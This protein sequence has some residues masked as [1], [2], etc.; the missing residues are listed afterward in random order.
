MDGIET[1]NVELKNQL[2][3]TRQELEATRIQINTFIDNAPDAIITISSEDYRITSFNPGAENMFG[4]STDEV[5]GKNV[6]M[7]MPEP[8]RSRHDGYVEHYLNTGEKRIIGRIRAEKAIRK[9]GEVFDINLS[10]SE[11]DLPSGKFFNAIIRDISARVNA[12]N[13]LRSVLAAQ[14]EIA[15]TLQESML[16]MPMSIP[17]VEFAHRYHSATESAAVGGDIYDIFELDEGR[18]GFLIADAEGHGI[19]AAAATTLIKNGV[20][21]FS[22]GTSSPAKVVARTNELIQRFPG[23]GKLATM[24]YGELDTQTGLVRYCNAGHPVPIIKSGDSVTE[25]QCGPSLP[26]GAFATAEYGDCELKL[27]SED[28]IVLYTDGITEARDGNELFG[29]ERLAE[30][31]RVTEVGRLTEWPGRLFQAVTEFSKGKLSDDVAIF[32]LSRST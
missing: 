12:E 27:G 1:I 11:V 30:V 3:E 20:R 18:V 31:I 13:D 10:V 2:E 26:V 8:N 6:E 5:V 28:V 9:N 23:S 32:V 7:L 17:G 14:Q 29:D 15:R 19:G 25:V 22:I 4:Y 21:A 24:F 16:T